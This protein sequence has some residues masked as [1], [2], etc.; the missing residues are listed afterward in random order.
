V[1]DSITGDKWN[2]YIFRTGRNSSQDAAANAAALD[3]PGVVV[4][5]LA[6]DTAFGRDGVKASRES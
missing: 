3:Q 5:T 6:N 4:A 1:A 2:K